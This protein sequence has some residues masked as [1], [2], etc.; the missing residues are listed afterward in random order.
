M[1]P[2]SSLMEGHARKYEG[3]DRVLRQQSESAENRP[4]NAGQNGAIA[5]QAARAPSAG[6]RHGAE[7]PATKDKATGG[8]GKKWLGYATRVLQ[9]P[10][11]AAPHFPPRPPPAP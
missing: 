11:A 6:E 9:P 8:G 1:S 4:N 10:R 3:G 5:N 2:I 7:T